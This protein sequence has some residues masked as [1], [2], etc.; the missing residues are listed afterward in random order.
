MSDTRTDDGRTQVLVLGG[1]M[2]GSAM[3]LDLAADPRFQV[4]VA[5]RSEEALARIA[6]RAAA[7]AS[8][9]AAG[10]AAPLK[11]L[12][13]DLADPRAVA[14]L[15]AGSDLV[16]GALASVLGLQTLRAVI[17]AGK[18]YVDISFMAED[19]LELDALA[20][21]RGVCAVVDCGVAPG[22]SNM[23][24]GYAAARMAPCT[25]LEIYVGGLPVERRWPFEYKAPF[26]P[27]DVL[28]EYTRPA[29]LVER[30]EVVVREALSEPEYLQF[31]GVGTLEAFN[32]DGLRSL[33][34]TLKVPS[35]KEKTMRYPGHIALM[36]VFRETGLFS[37]EPVV[38]RAAPGA[39]SAAGPG[40]A[41]A[42]AA[43]G[44]VSVRPLD[45]TAALMFPKWTFDEREADLTVMRVAAEGTL[46]GRRARMVWDLFDRYDPETDTRSMSR[47]TGF[48]A[49]IV[50]R[51]LHEGRFA[52]PGVHPPETLG[53]EPGLLDAVLAELKHRGITYAARTEWLDEG[54]AR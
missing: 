32:T 30:G 15:A 28:E 54:V 38:V 45:V 20:R 12:T 42:G 39:P 50:A 17:E 40:P 26:A 1:G 41:G 49:T 6:R 29:R 16:L 51:L 25:H 31:A 46:D 21:E 8:G 24:C 44:T 14:R 18:P 3:A 2:V 43:A 10:G 7:N 22:M 9:G 27:H 34:R 36:A 53:A 33:I 35:M 52:R 19:A 4:T 37:K 5:D 23:M 47:T 48:P 11:T 13:A